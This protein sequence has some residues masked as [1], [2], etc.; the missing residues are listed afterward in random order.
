MQPVFLYPTSRQYPFDKVCEQIVR[1]LEKR[2]WQV[3]GIKVDFNIY[4][5]GDKKYRLAR[6]IE[7]DDLDFRLYF[8]RIQGSLGEDGYYNDTA[9]VSRINIPLRELSVYEHESGPIY[10]HYV[11][12]NWGRDRYD[13]IHSGKVNSKL[14]SK[15]K[16][17]LQYEGS[18]RAGF[19]YL[20]RRAPYLVA[21]NDLG[22]EYDPVGRERKWYSTDRMFTR[23]N[24]YLKNIVLAKI[25][26]HPIPDEKIDIFAHNP[27][28]LPE[29]L[30]PIYTYI[31]DD[32]GFHRTIERIEL[33]K[34][35]P[36][37]LEPRFRYALAGSP[38][39]V[40]LGNRPR[41]G[42]KEVPKIAYDGFL[43]CSFDT[44]RDFR[45]YGAGRGA[46]I[47]PANADGVYI[48]DNAPYEAI[49]EEY[50]AKLDTLTDEEL[51]ARGRRRGSLSNAELDE[52]IRA[53]SRTIIP[54]TEY[55][56]GQFTDPIVL[57]NRELSFDE[58][59]L[60]DKEEPKKEEPL[61]AEGLIFAL[62]AFVDCGL[63]VVV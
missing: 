24:Q 32:Y 20:G 61:T 1:E 2:N 10:Y 54:I 51:A 6:C 49:R 60:C 9:A 25:L 35:D 7:S 44:P 63:L 52:A 31:A 57:I 29:N 50:W 34:A 33:G 55:Q 43:W 11:G 18:G 37:Q 39:L 27:I 62:E 28:P 8:G 42:E 58:V 12:D 45:H 23:F 41:M 38:R 46:R 21:D 30:P 22:R 40:P 16:T 14:D 4:G 19:Y 17:Y 13:F 48:C 56:P 36:S 3:P 5:S 53:R 26:E 47:I 15:P 59:E